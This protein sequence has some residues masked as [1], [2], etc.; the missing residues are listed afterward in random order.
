M[1]R[2]T[3][4][5]RIDW[6]RLIRSESVG[7]RTF[8]AL[9]NR[10]GGAGAA[11]DA[12]PGLA[13]RG[14]RLMLKM[15][16]QAE[17][18]RELE[19]AARLGARFVALGEPEY[20]RALQAIDTAPPLIAVRGAADVLKGPMVAIVGSRNASASGLTFTERLAR[21]LGEAGF[22]VVSGL[23]RGID[24]CAHKAALATGTAAVLAGGHDRVYPAENKPLLERIVAEGGSVLSEMPFGWEPR[25][26]DFPRR[27]RIVSGLSLGVVVVEAARRSGSLITAR[28]ALE[29]G[30]EVFAVPG[31][32][33]DPRAEGTNDLIRQGATL[34]AAAEHVASALAPL[35]GREPPPGGAAEE[36]SS[37]PYADWRPLWDELDLGELP[38][39]LERPN[40]SAEAF[41]NA[42]EDNGDET[43]RPVIDFLGPAPVSVDDLARQSG[44]PIRAVQQALLELELAGRLER[45]GGN[46]VSLAPDR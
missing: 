2:L 31:S 38:A 26:R 7:P 5:Q 28:F 13:R 1:T 11:L 35:I 16:T 4:E 37:L 12:L 3:D 36:P 42:A 20:P 23:A 44:L 39:A 19:Q 27:N 10:F 33:M 40:L 21:A 32:P 30:R 17:A 41:Q 46:A 8:R 6:L 43:P 14:G 22:V 18:E 34:C 24:T 15:T 9:I 29:Q 45:H 25:G